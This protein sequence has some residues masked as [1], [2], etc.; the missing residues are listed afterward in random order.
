MRRFFALVLWRLYPPSA[1]AVV[2]CL[3]GARMP[4]IAE[5]LDT[6]VRTVRWR[7]AGSRR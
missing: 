7:T 1:A 6:D 5:E 2:F 3:K 4:S